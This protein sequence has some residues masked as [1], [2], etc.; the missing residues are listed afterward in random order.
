[1]VVRYEEAL[2]IKLS[3]SIN[4]LIK[5]R[6]KSENVKAGN[7]T[8]KEPPSELKNIRAKK[9][10][11]IDGSVANSVDVHNPHPH[12]PMEHLKTNNSPL[13]P[14]QADKVLD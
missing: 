12:F 13:P 9:N 14:S 5:Y 6:L 10:K 11:N 4:P 3:D 7:D 2:K 1:M 8:N